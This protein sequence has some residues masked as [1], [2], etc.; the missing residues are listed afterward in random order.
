MWTMAGVDFEDLRNA[1]LLDRGHH[2][3]NDPENADRPC[4]YFE[5]RL[6][7]ETGK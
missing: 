3:S 4:S 2:G 6:Q 5:L 1:E 7:E